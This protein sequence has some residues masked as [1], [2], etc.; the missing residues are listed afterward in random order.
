MAYRLDSGEDEWLYSQDISI[1]MAPLAS[2]IRRYRH[3][4]GHSGH[5][6]ILGEQGTNLPSPPFPISLDPVQANHQ[7]KLN[8]R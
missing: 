7:L 5:R 2:T 3:S 8:R 4:R 6:G 1:E